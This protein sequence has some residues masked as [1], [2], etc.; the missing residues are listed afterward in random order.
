MAKFCSN[1][2]NEM[3]DEAV[4]CVKCGTMVGNVKKENFNSNTNTNT[5]TN[6]GGKKK[7]LPTWAIVLIVVGC[8]VLIPLIILAILFFIGYNSLKDV[9]IDKIKDDF[10]DYIEE[11]AG[12][13][14]VS[15]TIGDTLTGE[16]I[17]ITLNG[18]YMYESIGDEYIVDTPD[19]G[20][21]YLLFF[22]DVENISD[23]NKYISY[24][25][26]NGYA[27]DIQTSITILF[28]DVDGIEALSSDLAP[29]KKAK[30]F[31]AFEVDKTWKE[32]EIHYKENLWEE[33]TLI[34]KVTNSNEDA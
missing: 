3:V 25:D 27:D 18:A 11:N 14:S 2:G 13:Y 8:V 21:E 24:Y 31:V 12:E 6:N 16:D 30:G 20:K 34:F 28:N 5:N 19:E 23:D 10:N 29:G 17:R 26:F 4:M 22:F 7:G 32:F 33:N 15:G 9:D 1:C